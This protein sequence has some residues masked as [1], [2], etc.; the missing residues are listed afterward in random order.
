[1][2]CLG[3][4]SKETVLVLD[5]ESALERNVRLF[6][7]FNLSQLSSPLSYSSLVLDFLL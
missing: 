2:D 5:L 7:F 4:C 3:S 1:M 6:V